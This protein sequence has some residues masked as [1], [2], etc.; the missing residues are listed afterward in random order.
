MEIEKILKLALSLK[1][2]KGNIYRKDRRYQ[3][4]DRDSVRINNQ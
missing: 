4:K 2:R 1:Y 3:E